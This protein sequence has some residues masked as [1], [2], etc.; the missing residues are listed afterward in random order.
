MEQEY[1]KQFYDILRSV[2]SDSA[3]S[4]SY[5]SL[6]TELTQYMPEPTIEYWTKTQWEFLKKCCNSN[7]RQF[8]IEIPDGEGGIY[9]FKE[10]VFETVLHSGCVIVA[11]RD[12][13]SMVYEIPSE[14]F[15]ENHH[16]MPV[17]VRYLM[18]VVYDNWI[19]IKNLEK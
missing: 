3:I 17:W 18:R 12:V 7:L 19:L 16:I 6:L 4:Q 1:L 13:D 8:N 5:N 2:N 11:K 9:N 10:V 14:H 15:K